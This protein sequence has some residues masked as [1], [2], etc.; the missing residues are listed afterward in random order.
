MTLSKYAAVAGTMT[1]TAQGH[2]NTKQWPST[3][4]VLRHTG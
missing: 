2:N 4:R 3:H 1:K